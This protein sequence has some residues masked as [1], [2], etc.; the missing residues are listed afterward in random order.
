LQNWPLGARVLLLHDGE[1]ADVRAQV[2]A[3]ALECAERIGGATRSDLRGAWTLVVGTPQRLLEFEEGLPWGESLRIAILEADARTLR[4][5]LRRAD[6]EY[7]V[8]RPFHPEALRLLMLHL[9]Y[10]G[11]ERRRQRRVGIGAAVR[12]R[13]G[14][15]RRE[16]VLVDLSLSG[17]RLLTDEWIPPGRQLSLQL[18]PEIAGGSSLR[19]LGSVVRWGRAEQGGERLVAV[20]F[21]GLPTRTLRRLEGVIG[22]HREG[23]AVFSGELEPAV[24]SDPAERRRLPR[25]GLGRRIIALGIHSAPVLLGRDISLAGMRVEPNPHLRVGDLLQL[26]LHVRAGDEPLVVR[27]RVARDDGALGLLLE[28]Q[29]LS[30]EAREA[31]AKKVEALPILELDEAGFHAGVIVSHVLQQDSLGRESHA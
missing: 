26:A 17:C 7:V 6:I 8:R 20:A 31:L 14:W 18:P 4:A 13:T 12:L 5:A 3:L 16:G 28:F 2:D 23:P 22:L 30:A 27:S 29:E 25:H 9:L 11:P 19:L 24:G 21:G 1:L 10:K 15:R